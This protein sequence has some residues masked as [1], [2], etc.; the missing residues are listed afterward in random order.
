MSESTSQASF[1]L[2]G[3]QVTLIGRFWVTPEDECDK[4]GTFGHVSE[5]NLHAIPKRDLCM[6]RRVRR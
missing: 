4:L 5:E 3:F 1:S 2:A 6:R